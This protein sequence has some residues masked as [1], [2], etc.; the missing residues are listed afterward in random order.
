MTAPATIPLFHS[1]PPSHLPKAPR[2]DVRQ[3]FAETRDEVT[4]TRKRQLPAFDGIIG[5]SQAMRQVMAL[6]EKVALS[7][8][9]S[10]LLC[11]ESGTGKDLA[12]KA[13]H[14]A[15]VRAGA[16]FMNITC[17]ALPESLLESELFRH[18]RGTF[19][20]DKQRQL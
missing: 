3:D 13:I 18:V 15:S 1:L 8:S 5:D 20:D 17:S 19:T 2:A 6:L 12:A 10:V 14:N 9:A 4:V 16:P 7:P 11:G